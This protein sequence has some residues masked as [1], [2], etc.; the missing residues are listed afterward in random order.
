MH[1]LTEFRNQGYEYYNINLLGRPLTAN[2]PNR[3]KHVT[4][5]GQARYPTWASSVPNFNPNRSL[6]LAWISF[7][8]RMD[9]PTSFLNFPFSFSIIAVCFFTTLSENHA[10]AQNISVP[11]RQYSRLLSMWVEA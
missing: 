2:L 5:D 1:A 7:F 11:T 3:G 10:S 9:Y 4:H 6:G 8:R